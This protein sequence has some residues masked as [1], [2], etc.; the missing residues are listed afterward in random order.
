MRDLRKKQ[1]FTIT[2]HKLAIHKEA[3]NMEEDKKIW[4][5]ELDKEFL[6]KVQEAEERKKV[7]EKERQQTIS[8]F[9]IFVNCLSANPMAPD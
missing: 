9:K 3:A 7:E 8:R 4:K 6:E 5:Y 2:G 1:N